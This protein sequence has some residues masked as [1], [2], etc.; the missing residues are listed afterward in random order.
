MRTKAPKV[1]EFQRRFVCTKC[2][3]PVLQLADYERVYSITQPRACS[4][5]D[6]SGMNFLSIGELD[7]QNCKDYQEI[8]I[9][10]QVK[11]GGVGTMPA[12]MWVTLE[13]DI[14]DL[15]KPGDNVTIW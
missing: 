14:V 13:D 5:L 3:S 4:N 6:C 8:K 9:Q 1:L 12:T 11:D 15:C 7:P 10:E 2:K